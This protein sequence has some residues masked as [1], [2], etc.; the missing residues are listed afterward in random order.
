M[1]I[2]TRRDGTSS[3]AWTRS[4]LSWAGL[5]LYSEPTSSVLLNFDVLFDLDENMKPNKL[6]LRC[7]INVELFVL[8]CEHFY[9]ARSK[10]VV[11]GIFLGGFWDQACKLI[12]LGGVALCC[13]RRYHGPLER[14]NISVSWVQDLLE[15]V[16]SAASRRSSDEPLERKR[17]ETR[18]EK[19]KE[20]NGFVV[21]YWFIRSL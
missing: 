15:I 2:K 1:T 14:R 5:H 18:G 13:K 8:V 20:M 7:P 17:G 11:G 4:C 9:R 3:F 6:S 21:V 12:W 19:M 16:G 10:F